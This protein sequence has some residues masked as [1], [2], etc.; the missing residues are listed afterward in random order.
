[1]TVDREM[2][3]GDY[4]FIERIRISNIGMVRRTVIGDWL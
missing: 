3:V 1:M 4:F 2:I